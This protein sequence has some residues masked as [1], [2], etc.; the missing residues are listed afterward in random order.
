[1]ESVWLGID[2]GGTNVVM[3]L[4][5]RNGNV[6][7]KK[8]IP[9]L[10]ADGAARVLKR[11]ID[12][13]EA[14]LAETGTPISRLGGIGLGVP[15]LVDAKRGVV[16]LA[17]NLNWRQVAVSEVFHRHFGVPVHVDNDVRAA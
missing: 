2:V 12:A 9:T 11:I 10:A 8:R 7:A 16:R 13:V 14:M 15:G 5:D 17:V 4:G 3:A 1:M 6:F